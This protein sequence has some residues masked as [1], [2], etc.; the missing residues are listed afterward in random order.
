VP[1]QTDYTVNG[2]WLEQTYTLP[3]N[4]LITIQAKDIRR[5]RTGYH[6]HLRVSFNRDDTLGWTVINLEKDEDRLRIANSCYKKLEG[7]GGLDIDLALW[8]NVAN[9]HAI[10]NFCEGLT[11]AV[12]AAH[13]AE[14]LTLGDEISPLLFL[15]PHY[16]ILGGGTILYGPKGAG[17]TMLALLMALGL[18]YG[19]GPFAAP[20]RHKVLFVQL[21]RSRETFGRRIQLA[22]RALGLPRNTPMLTLIAR[23]RSL[24]EI[25]NVIK[26]HVEQDCVKLVILDSISRA[27]GGEGGSLKNDDTANALMDTLNA[28]A[29]AWLALGHTSHEGKTDAT[30]AH[31]FGSIHFE[32]AA[33]VLVQIKA[34]R[35]RVGIMGISLEVVDANDFA[36][37]YRQT[38]AI[39][40]D[41]D[42]LS[43][44]RESKPRE[45]PELSTALR[46]S[47]ADKLYSY[48]TETR[49]SDATSAAAA[50]GVSR[51]TVTDLLGDTD[52]Y[53]RLGKEGREVMYALV[54]RYRDDYEGKR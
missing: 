40:F 16:V 3:S 53:V 37:G 50:T 46:L 21:E 26:R 31:V 39:E 4:N 44:V 12:F 5:E 2:D 45:F 10:D 14:E 35:G 7:R 25:K 30:K 48:M 27:G 15:I 8:T 19:V 17:K 28:I 38:F 42:G 54:E 6:A 11:E 41:D 24:A 1:S 32:N 13:G 22:A 52:L 29:P 23:G 34:Q 47:A 43:N 51:T 20:V 36:P 9:K 49:K 18:Q 33:D